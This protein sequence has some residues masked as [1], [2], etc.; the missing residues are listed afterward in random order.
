MIHNYIAAWQNIEYSESNWNQFAVA[1]NDHT[2]VSLK[3]RDSSTA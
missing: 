3:K 2:G 1:V